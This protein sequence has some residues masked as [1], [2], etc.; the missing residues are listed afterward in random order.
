[1]PTE[2]VTMAEFQDKVL[3][4]SADKLIVVDFFATWCGPCIMIAPAYEAMSKKYTDVVFYKVDVD[5][6]REAMEH[7]GVGCMPTFK[8]F[9]GGQMLKDEVKG[10]SEAKLAHIIEANK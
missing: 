5:K 8:L 9:R 2:L 1:M 10:A 7:C 4:A 6:N 3:N